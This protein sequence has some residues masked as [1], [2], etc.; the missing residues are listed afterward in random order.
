MTKEELFK[1]KLHETM[2]V[3]KYTFVLRVYNGWIYEQSVENVDSTWNTTSTYV[4]EAF[5]VEAHTTNSY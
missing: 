3:N 2:E 1:M 4:P 5:N